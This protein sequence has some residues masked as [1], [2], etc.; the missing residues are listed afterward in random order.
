[1]NTNVFKGFFVGLFI[2]F[3]QACVNESYE[4][5]PTTED[6]GRTPV[7]FVASNSSATRT[8][9]SPTNGTEWVVGDSI[10][11]YMLRPAT[12]IINSE[13]RNKV[14]TANSAGPLD[15]AFSA[16][17]ANK[18]YYG[19]NLPYKFI[20]YYPYRKEGSLPGQIYEY[21][22]AAAT[23]KTLIYPIDVSNQEDPAK[24]DVLYS[25]NVITH[26][27]LT[28]VGTS[29]RVTLQFKHVLSK[30]VINIKKDNNLVQDGMR[31]TYNG[32]SLTADM[33]LGNNDLTL[34]TNP[35]PVGGDI[36]TILS[37]PGELKNANL[38]G[39]GKPGDTQAA[40]SAPAGITFTDY[41]TTYQAI[42]IPH[43]INTTGLENIVFFSGG[44]R[45]FTWNLSGLTTGSKPITKFEPGKVY[46][47]WVELTGS[48]PVVIIGSIT[49]WTP[50]DIPDVVQV[51]EGH[52]GDTAMYVFP[53]R[54]DSLAV[55]YIAKGDF[56]MGA[57][58]WR[59][60]SV[61]NARKHLVTISK[62]FQMS[63][64][65][66]T[67]TQF[68]KFLNACGVKA[69]GL[70]TDSTESVL[71]GTK[72]NALAAA[73]QGAS[74]WGLKTSTNPVWEPVAG[75]EDAPVT[76]VSWLGARAY[77]RWAG[78][79]YGG[80]VPADYH[81]YGDLP[82]EAQW[83]YAA[84]ANADTTYIYM[85]GTNDGSGMGT[86]AYYN[87]PAGPPASVGTLEGN[88]WKLND[89]FGSV[90]EYTRDL[91][92]TANVIPNYPS[93]DAIDPGEVPAASGY[94][95]SRGGHYNSS[96]SDMRFF[97]RGVANWNYNSVYGTYY[98]SF[99]VV[100]K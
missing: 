52:S 98:V 34:S 73:S 46:T 15:I 62:G 82:T 87:H 1:M 93:G 57:G 3:A 4:N 74:N 89:M 2:F 18:L 21:L 25:D 77:A 60:P 7:R 11:V 91:V 14:Y 50:V 51:H 85:D 71:P 43:D 38:P 56:T 75:Y 86:Y 70:G 53:N 45:Q 59:D 23:Q 13:A 26:T 61:T 97:Y 65:M 69:D 88:A 44:N 12:S 17:D 78:G 32:L 42:V 66:I 36:S 5:C 35:S 8:S 76:M 68:A 37:N 30:V 80:N 99:R 9:V 54:A 95:V 63:R 47:F 33:D 31:A 28:P 64:N 79:S 81:A 55:S 20:A 39:V 96:V 22:P 19:D 94:P 49:D 58:S 27:L 6:G 92:T 16:D 41:D 84:R 67:N 83:E 29:D 24:I 72:G 40:S 48:T 90:W 10:G 100:F